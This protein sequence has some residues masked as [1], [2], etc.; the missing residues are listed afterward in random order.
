MIKDGTE[1]LLCC[2]NCD[3]VPLIHREDSHMEIEEGKPIIHIEKVWIECPNCGTKH[4][5][6][7]EGKK[8]EVAT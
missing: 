5:W 8:L 3:F 1:L 7:C 4:H 2:L 6:D